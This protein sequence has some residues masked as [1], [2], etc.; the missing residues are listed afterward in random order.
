MDAL[1]FAATKIQPPR[2][3]VRQVERP[4]LH[5]AVAEALAACRV[6]LLQ[7][8]AG[9]GKT[10]VLAA[11]LAALPAAWA[12]AWVSLDPDDGA[13]R[14][15]ACLA[16]ALEPWD[17]PWRSAPEA[18]VALAGGDAPAQRRAA[19]EIVNAL[20][21][22]DA[23]HG[24]IVLDDLHRV[25]DDGALALLALLVERLPTNWT[26][27][28]ASRALPPLAPLARLRATGELAEFDQAALRFSPDEARALCAAEAV[29]DA[30]TDE[31]VA[32]SAGWPAALRLATL[33]VARA[34]PLLGEGHVFDYLA[35]EV[36]DG[37]PQP[38]HDFLL[39]SSVLPE[40]TA[41][42][43][44]AVSGDPRAAEWL[45]EIERRGLFATALDA[46]ERTLVLHD[47]FRDALAA[48]LQARL[49][50]E[51][52]QL[53][54]RAAAGEHDPVRRVGWLLRAGDWAGA[55][56]SLAD[57]A[58]GL[59]MAGAARE[60][61]QLVEQ[62][63]PARRNARLSLLAA[64]AHWVRW[65]WS[66]MARWCETAVAAA[67]NADEHALARTY[68]AVA[69]Y[70]LDRN[71]EAEALLAALRGEP[72]APGTRALALSADASQHFRRGDHER[73][74]AIYAELLALLEHGE[75]LL[76]WW[77]CA[78]PV[79]WTTI[80]GLP[81]LIQRY[82]NG[83]WARVGERA[84]PLRA[85][86]HLLQAYGHLWAG[87]VDAA[88]AEC[89]AAAADAQWLGVTGELRV[90]LAIFRCQLDAM[91][92]DGAAL[93]GRIDAL[94]AVEA[95]STPER[96]AVWLHQVA[97]MAVRWCDAV[98]DADALRHWAGRLRENPLV[99]PAPTV[100]R[101]V[102]ARARVAAAEG[103]WADAAR[104]FEQLRPRLPTIDVWGQR[105]DLE[106]RAALACH[107]A[108][109]S[110]DARAL[111]HGVLAR[112]AGERAP[113]QALLPGPAVLAPLAASGL[114]EGAALQQ[115]DELL[116]LA[117]TMRGAPPPAPASDGPLSTR[118]REVLERIAAG[119]S[120]KLIAR[121]LDISPATV[122]RHV[123][124]ILDKLGLASRG[125]AGAW[126]RDNAQR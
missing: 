36:L 58:E 31:L 44:A 42:R 77:E 61:L 57:A 54:A 5:A 19:A 115:L 97:T 108:G 82:L 18:L 104:H 71:A 93:A 89:E 79:N 6:V 48:R 16:A 63:P 3:R 84:L 121:T 111:L 78:P 11:Q 117:R 64:L 126:L 69:L 75:P 76:R 28:V 12:R 4:A 94:L 26:L 40:L 35:S 119:D 113:G 96:R 55:E 66:E 103:R 73:L 62:F 109:R 100:P 114:V 41:P 43:A 1:H 52:P 24:V 83:A 70:P 29:S 80:A 23:P 122:K 50:H 99:D 27:L 9:F 17:L 49:P 46:H 112:L 22:C 13:E 125:Q 107:R 123:A 39:R 59:F 34:N 101:A 87:R 72:L 86:L 25:R 105:A 14:L 10:S 2:L 65:Q 68:L 60:V 45:D 88:R 102:A 90:G 92:G 37:L 20:A 95:D 33:G 32:R 56:A 38:L 8:P 120:N 85:E 106:F 74:A 98:G 21:D 116:Q 30:R 81:P 124:N 47:L 53:L 67:A 91:A 110:A 15:C 7:A 51:L 118:E